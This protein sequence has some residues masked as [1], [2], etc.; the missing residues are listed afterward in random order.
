MAKDSDIRIRFSGEDKE[1]IVRAVKQVHSELDVSKWARGVLKAEALRVLNGLPF[2]DAELDAKA[3]E[4]E[5][6]VTVPLTPK[7]R[8]KVEM[9]FGT[10]PADTLTAQGIVDATESIVSKLPDSDEVKPSTVVLT[11]TPDNLAKPKTQ[12][13]DLKKNLGLKSANKVEKPAKIEESEEDY[14][15]EYMYEPEDYEVVATKHKGL[16]IDCAEKGFVRGIHGV[17][18]NL[19]GVVYKAVMKPET[20]VCLAY[21]NGAWHQVASAN[22]GVKQGSITVTKK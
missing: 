14:E 3:S 7:Q 22:W 16:P 21:W 15:E 4:V 19:G 18:F 2:R 5:V 9:G 12:I 20:R 11:E 13:D 8:S 1:L 10:K 6:S 17:Y